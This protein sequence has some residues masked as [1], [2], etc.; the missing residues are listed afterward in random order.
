ME[1]DKELFDALLKKIAVSYDT[2]YT[3]DQSEMWKK[4]AQQIFNGEYPEEIEP[5][6]FI[7]KSELKKFSHYLDI[8]SGQTFVDLGCGR[9]GPGMWIAQE[10]C[11][12][13]FGIDLSA[14]A[15]NICKKRM[16]D[17][18]L[19]GKSKFKD[20][21]ICSTGL[22]DAKFDGAISIDMLVLVQDKMAAIREAFRI[23]KPDSKFV[24]TTWEVNMSQTVK[25]YR[26]LLQKAGFYVEL[27]EETPG[28]KR[29]QRE[30]Y[31]SYVDA[32]QTLIDELG[33]TTY[34]SWLKEAQIVLPLLDVM[35]RIFVVAI[36]R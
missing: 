26:P 6:S 28:W 20:S 25:D 4:K 14:N 17:F 8:K 3:K 22:S 1:V 34:T 11:S 24:F 5:D 23:L 10:T 30:I 18:G 15:V 32:D 33:E 12:N 16:T 7:S 29:I 35:R 21:D 27:Y 13:Y 36:K 19:E 2:R 31:Q 9:G